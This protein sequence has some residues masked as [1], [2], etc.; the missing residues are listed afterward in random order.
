MV[1]SNLLLIALWLLA[2][3][4]AFW[5][6][7]CDGDQPKSGITRFM[8]LVAVCALLLMLLGACISLQKSPYPLILM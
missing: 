3:S 4:W 8:E 5:C 6:V 7:V 1:N 2:F